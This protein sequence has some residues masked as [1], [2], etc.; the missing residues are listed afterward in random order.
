[1]HLA[2]GF[3][4]PAM[5]DV[6]EW[7]INLFRADSREERINRKMQQAAPCL[8]VCDLDNMYEWF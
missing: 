7:E 2:T 6:N 1:V 4:V 3:L 5:T 8:E